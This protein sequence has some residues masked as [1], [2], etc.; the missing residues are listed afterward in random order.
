MKGLVENDAS[1]KAKTPPSQKNRGQFH[2]W[3]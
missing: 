3:Y 2:A 1:E